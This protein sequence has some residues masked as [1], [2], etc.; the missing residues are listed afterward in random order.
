MVSNRAQS[1][2]QSKLAEG[3]L[4]PTM[5]QVLE[6]EY[7]S[8]VAIMDMPATDEEPRKFAAARLGNAIIAAINENPDADLD[9]MR[10]MVMA[11]YESLQA[12]RSQTAG[13][14]ASLAEIESI[15][16]HAAQIASDEGNVHRVVEI[17]ESTGEMVERIIV[18]DEIDLLNDVDEDE[19]TIEGLRAQGRI[20]ANFNTLSGFDPE[21][22][23]PPIINFSVFKNG[24][25]C[26]PNCG[27][28]KFFLQ[29]SVEYV[30][31]DC[32][33]EHRQPYVEDEE[34]DAKFMDKLLRTA[35]D[36][37]SE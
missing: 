6:R 7:I 2:F 11:H 4:N 10:D 24:M 26:C 36:E 8:Q 1:L 33:T 19:I 12:R 37:S 9:E 25:W 34:A 27:S 14:N 35:K 21:V 30:C 32:G 5:A 15:N 3:T 13:S 17:N 29:S 28:T 18:T 20:D 22:I 23:A 31:Y 16:S